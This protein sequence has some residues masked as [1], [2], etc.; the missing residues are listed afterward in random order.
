MFYTL[1]H[2]SWISFSPELESLY[3]LIF[4]VVLSIF[5]VAIHMKTF[6]KVLHFSKGR[7]VIEFSREILSLQAA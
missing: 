1:L 3:F 6:I 5:E 4:Y 2:I 7:Q